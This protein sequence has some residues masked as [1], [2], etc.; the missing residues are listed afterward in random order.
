VVA[1]WHAEVVAARLDI[2]LDQLLTKALLP[3]PGDAD[4][5]FDGVALLSTFNA[6]IDLCDRFAPFDTIAP[7]HS[8][9]HN[10]RSRAGTTPVGLILPK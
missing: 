10:A 9:I 6:Q 2:L 1:A 3:N 5:V 4:D 8:A 7:R